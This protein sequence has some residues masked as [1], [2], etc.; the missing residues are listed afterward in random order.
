MPLPRQVEAMIAVLRRRY[1]W[2]LYGGAR[3][4]AKALD[5]RTMIPT[6]YG[7][8]P[9]SAI[10]VGDDVLDECGQPCT[11]SDSQWPR[12]R[13]Y[14][15]TF[16]DGTT[17]IAGAQHEWLTKTKSE[18]AAQARRTDA[19]TGS[20]RTT[21]E[22]ARTLYCGKEINHSID[23]ARPIQHPR[24]YF[25]IDPYVL[26]AWLGDGNSDDGAITTADDEMLTAILSCGYHV[27]TH[28]ARYHYDISNLKAQLRDLGVLNHKHV[29]S[30]YMLGSREQRLS[31]LQGLMDTDGTCARDGQA[32]FTNCNKHL[33]DAVYQL[34]CSLG[35]KAYRTEGRA[36]LHGRDCGPVWRVTWTAAVPVF[37][38][39]R[40]AQRLPKK[41]NVRQTRRLIVRCDP[42]PEVPLRC[43]TVASP[44]HLFLCTDAHIPTHNSHFLRWLAYALCLRIPRF[45]AVLLRRTY[46]ELEKSHMRRIPAEVKLLGADYTPSARPPVI[47]FHNGSV[48]ELGHC[49]DPQDVENYLS[50]E[51][52]LVLPDEL[53]TF[54]EDMILKIASSA[55]LY[56]PQ[57]KPCVVGSTN[58][59]AAWV[60]DRW[61]TKEVDLDRFP[62][63]EP[64]EYHFIQSLLD[65]NPYPDPEYER[66]LNALDPD[67]YQAWRMGSWDAFEGQYFKEFR[68]DKHCEVLEIPKEIPRIGGFD[69]GYS[70]DPAVLLYAVAL[71]DGHLHVEREIVWR[72]TVAEDVA[73]QI[74]RDCTDHGIPLT[75][76]WYDPSMNIRSGQSGE[77]I[78]ETMRRIG[79]PLVVSAHERI[80]GW[81]RLRHWL[82]PN[83]ATGKPWMTINAKDCPGL[84]RTLPALIHDEHVREDVDKKSTI[85]HWAEALRRLLMG[86]PAPMQIGKQDHEPPPDSA[87]ALMREAMRANLPVMGADRVAG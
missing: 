35:I 1:R 56:H 43:L 61:I 46:P 25:P 47:K 49:Q 5:V 9:L 80:N 2:I 4:G 8:K 57:F 74:K 19:P 62:Y 59:G 45:Q 69:W 85:D 18:R 54:E 75:A 34:A 42:V 40:K 7:L 10:H 67:T 58:P 17:L 78:A 33:A 70:P 81:Q 84:V 73:A 15:L 16:D 14:Q 64:S 72:E 13:C 3:G 38:L 11:V 63:Y 87:G 79:L 50:A 12:D 53:G 36:K 23:V 77:S 29:P 55:R 51:Y 48:L 71:P 68:K 39:S 83:P 22:I 66:M 26:G 37:R 86:R 24:R 82:R 76:I 20:L 52:H 28:A 6:P 31:L 65:D 60:K 32:S 27:T 30:N 44:S 21:E 41:T